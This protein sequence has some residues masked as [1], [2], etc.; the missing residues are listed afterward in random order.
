MSN[1][2]SLEIPDCKDKLSASHVLFKGDKG[3]KSL[4]VD[5]T[6]K[7]LGGRSGSYSNTPRTR[8]SSNSPRYLFWHTASAG[9][10]GLYDPEGRKG[11][12]VPSGGA[13]LKGLY[14][15]SRENRVKV[16]G[17]FDNLSFKLKTKLFL[18]G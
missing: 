17:R 8:G 15:S 2:K 3:N 10:L 12:M 6:A 11:L 9:I 14:E 7:N 13:A 16:S 1:F 18:Y 4:G 5:K